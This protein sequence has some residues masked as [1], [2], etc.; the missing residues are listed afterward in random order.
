MVFGP[1]PHLGEV[2]PIGGSQD[3]SPGC[4]LVAV[5]A[6]IHRPVMNDHIAP[7]VTVVDGAVIPGLNDVPVLAVRSTEQCP[8]PVLVPRSDIVISPELDD[9]T[10]RNILIG[11]HEL[12][13]GGS[14]PGSHHHSCLFQTKDQHIIKGSEPSAAIDLFLAVSGF[15]DFLEGYPVRRSPHR[16]EVIIRIPFRTPEIDGTVEYDRCI[17]GIAGTNFKGRGPVLPIGGTVDLIRVPASSIQ[18]VVPCAECLDHIE[19]CRVP[20]ILHDKSFI[21]QNIGFILLFSI[22]GQG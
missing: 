1:M 9:I 8:A 11:P 4:F 18:L 12:F 10:Q 19:R 16:D 3:R 17:P 14:V 13:P 20:C 15:V 7:A 22:A 6:D 21:P 5:I 2:L